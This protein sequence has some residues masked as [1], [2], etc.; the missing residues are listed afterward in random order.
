MKKI[1]LLLIISI[2]GLTQVKGQVRYG[3]NTAEGVQIDYTNPRVFEIAEVQYTGL[4]TIEERALT[5]LVGIKVGDKISIPGNEI[6]DAIKKLW[7]QGIIA[8][9]QIWLTKIEGDRAFLEI[10]I[11]ERPRITKFEVEG[12]TSSQK[13]DLKEQIGV[14]G[15]VASAPL[16]K[17]SETLI[18][19]YFVAK[20]Y[21]NADVKTLQEA[22]STGTKGAQL[23]FVVDKMSKV[24]KP[25]RSL[26]SGL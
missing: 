23:T 17:N 13:S 21:L 11:S 22:D 4:S 14:I 20:G 15:K 18:K 2:C 12:V 25:M 24:R 26:V 9:V 1:F 3:V 10:K 8:D 19:K 5:G 16:I 6:S 7:K